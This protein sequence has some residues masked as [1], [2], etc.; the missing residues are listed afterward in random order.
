MDTLT[1]AYG[2]IA[3]GLV[4]MAAELFLPTHGILFGLGLAAG[5]VGVILSFSAGFS[6]GVTTLTVVVVVVPLFVMALLNLWPKTPMGKR[7]VL[8]GPDDDEAVA[9]MP[10]S[11]ELERLR[12]RFGRTLSPLRP[13]GVVDFDGK[14]VDTMTEGEMIDANQ[15]V[16]CIDI[17]GG[18]V[19]VRSVEKPPD[20]VEID[21]TLLG[22]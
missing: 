6:T 12:G 5:L 22:S 16:R 13:C 1:V 4:L 20:L 14:R 19:L 7:L 9:N 10:V 18:R 17:K 2:L 3:V 21:T 15:W 11:L 8:H